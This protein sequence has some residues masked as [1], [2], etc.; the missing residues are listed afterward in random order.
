[1]KTWDPTINTLLFHAG[2]R[3]PS[4]GKRLKRVTELSDELGIFLRN[5]KPDLSTLLSNEK[6]TCLSDTFDKVNEFNLSF[7]GKSTNILVLT[8][9]LQAFNRMPNCLLS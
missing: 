8:A 3:R 4:R 6:W 7:Q 2:V 5:I 1:M 9:K